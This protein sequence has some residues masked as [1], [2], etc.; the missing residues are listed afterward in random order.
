MSSKGDFE[1]TDA[2]DGAAD[3]TAPGTDVVPRLT[4]FFNW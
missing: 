3:R 4:L 2:Y 1:S